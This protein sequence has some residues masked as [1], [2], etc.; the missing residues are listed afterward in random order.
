MTAVGQSRRTK[1]AAASPDVRFTPIA[2]KPVR[3]N[4]VTLCAISSRHRHYQRRANLRCASAKPVPHTSA[5]GMEL[6][7][8]SLCGF[9]GHGTHLLTRGNEVR[10]LVRNL[11]VSFYAC[12]IGKLALQTISGSSAF[13]VSRELSPRVSTRPRVTPFFSSTSQADSRMLRSS[14]SLPEI[15]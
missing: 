2:T 7:I 13:F 4:E 14:C 10:V 6:I 1:Q 12:L 9:P 8:S 15:A 5:A 11:F 3:R